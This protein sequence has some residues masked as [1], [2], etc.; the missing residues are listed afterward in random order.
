[1]AKT[2]TIPLNFGTHGGK[3]RYLCEVQRS[4]RK[5]LAIHV[6]HRKVE[7]RSPLRASK[8]E[9][10][11]FINS[12]QDWIELRLN[13]EA[14]R[15]REA[16]RIERGGKIFY[17]ARELTIEFREGRKQRILVSGDR[18]IIQGHKLNPAKARA[19]VEQFLTDKANAYILP[20]AHALARYLGV[21]RKIREIKLRKTKSKWG[22]CTSKGDMQYNWLIM[23][24]PYSVVDYIITHEV[25]HLIHMDH[26]RRFWNLVDSVCPNSENYMRWLKDH[27]HRFWF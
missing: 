17:R 9:I 20:R 12:N 19:Q 7:V 5:T 10:E 6:T 14:I 16:T 26:S 23:M 11:E 22:H 15:A 3:P 4:R 2:R 24:A 1:M 27:E 18:F 13:E 8:R 25:C 21:G